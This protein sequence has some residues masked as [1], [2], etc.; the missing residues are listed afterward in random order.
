VYASPMATTSA[1]ITGE[2]TVPN[3]A[4]QGSTRLR[5]SMKYFAEPENACEGGYDGEIEDYCVNL[6]ANP[7]QYCPGPSNIDVLSITDTTAYITWSGPPSAISYQIKY[8]PYFDPNAVWNW[9]TGTN[10]FCLIKNLTPCSLYEYEVRTICDTGLSNFTETALFE[11]ECMTTLQSELD[12]KQTIVYPN[13][14]EEALN[15]NWR[16]ENGGIRLLTLYNATGAMVLNKTIDQSS[17]GEIINLDLGHLPTGI[18]LIEI[19]G[20][21][22]SEVHK[23]VKQ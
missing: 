22:F 5:V 19:Q 7:M 20:T 17:S 14:F 15:I 1:M 21:D 4:L 13:P 18:Y 10:D 23:I 8:K 9:I 2:F 11:T 6:Y 3:F 12:Q 16:E